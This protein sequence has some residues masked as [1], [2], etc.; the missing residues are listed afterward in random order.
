MKSR[1]FPN[2]SNVDFIQQVRQSDTYSTNKTNDHATSYVRIYN[3]V[4]HS[5]TWPVSR[6]IRLWLNMKQD[7]WLCCR[8]FPE[9]YASCFCPWLWPFHP[10]FLPIFK[11]AWMTQIN[12]KY[13]LNT[14]VEYKTVG[15][16]LSFCR[17]TSSIR[18]PCHVPGPFI[19]ADSIFTS[20][21]AILVINHSGVTN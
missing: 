14:I 4:T 16:S 2:Q 9:E 19:F 10:K 15:Q 6:Q 5:W 21:F 11:S 13:S 7:S 8:L 17:S 3:F 18:F 12:S 20:V 1:S